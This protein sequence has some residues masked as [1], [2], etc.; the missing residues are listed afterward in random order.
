MPCVNAAATDTTMAVCC[1]T[2]AA[3]LATWH[4]CIEGEVDESMLPARPVGHPSPPPLGRAHPAICSL[5]LS[6]LLERAWARSGGPVH[7][8][9][10]RLGCK[11]ALV[12]SSRRNI[13]GSV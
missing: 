1:A 5:A 6:A 12:T 8:C 3:S 4:H 2:M 7:T 13:S 9:Q 11:R 10:Y